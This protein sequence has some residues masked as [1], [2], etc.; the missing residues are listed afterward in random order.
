MT[1]ATATATKSHAL[2]KFISDPVDPNTRLYGTTSRQ[3]IIKRRLLCFEC[4]ELSIIRP[5]LWELKVA[6]RTHMIQGVMAA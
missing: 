3:Y 2:A 1:T 6:I 5:T 4:P